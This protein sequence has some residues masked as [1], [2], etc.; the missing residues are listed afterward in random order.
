MATGERA[1]TWN[2]GGSSSEY[3]MGKMSV[4]RYLIGKAR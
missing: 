1:D 4:S 2:A 3:K